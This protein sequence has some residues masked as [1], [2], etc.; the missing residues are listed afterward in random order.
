MRTR[1]TLAAITLGTLA[2]SAHAQANPDYRVRARF[3]TAPDASWGANESVGHAEFR[4]HSRFGHVYYGGVV[5]ADEF[6]FQVQIDY[7]DISGFDPEFFASPFNADYDVYINNAFVGRVFMSTE[8]LGLAELVYD[9]RHPN[10]P[11]LPL[12]ENFPDPVELFDVVSVFPATGAAPEIGAPLPAGDPMFQSELIEEFARGDAN[13]DG[14]VDEDDYAILASV[15]DP[16]HLL[17]EHVGPMAG[18]FTADNLA[19]LDDYDTLVANWT[20]SHD[21]PPEPEAVATPCAA[22]LAQPFGTLDFSDVLAFLTAFAAS[23]PEADLAEPI[24]TFDFSDV[25]AF[26][27]AFGAGCP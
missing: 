7:R 1:L 2:G 25:L 22:D 21:V 26:L 4:V 9:S 10:F 6:K 8:E 20:D 3:R 19:D 11:D 17:G 13:M 18:D 23:A 15:Y 12:P 27:A 14:K 5:R 24:G 16:F